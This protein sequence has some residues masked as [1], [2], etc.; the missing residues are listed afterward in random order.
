MKL[1]STEEVG[2]IYYWLYG[3]ETYCFNTDYGIW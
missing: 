1:I 2:G 3:N